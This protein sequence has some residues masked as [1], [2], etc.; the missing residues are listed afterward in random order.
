MPENENGVVFIFALAARKLRFEVDKVQ[1]PFPDCRARWGKRNVRIEFEFRSR[2]FETH[3]HSSRGCDLIVCWKHDWP[4]VPAGLEVIELRKAF[5]LDRDVWSVAYQERFWSNLPNSREP[6]GLWSVPSRAGPDDLLL[7]YRSGTASEEGAITDVF[8][9][10][11]PVER[12]KDPGWR[13][14]PDWMASIQLV[15]TLRRPLTYS[16]MKK[17][18]I[19]GGLESRPNRTGNWPGIYKEIQ[20]SCSPSH[21][22]KRYTPI[23]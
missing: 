15:A 22:L 9:V 17:L 3:G 6:T 16:R 11:T 21:S 2:N 5:G 13:A 4:G 18:G 1:S 10:H 23:P 14:E 19:A 12:V 8:R 20:R 7:V